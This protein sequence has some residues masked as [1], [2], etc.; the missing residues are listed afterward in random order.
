MGVKARFSSQLFSEERGTTADGRKGYSLWDAYPQADLVTY[1]SAFEGF[2]NAFVEAIYFRKPIVVNNYSIYATDIRPKGFAVIEFD[3]F[4]T[5][6]VVE[7][8]LE[9]LDS[10]TLQA[11]MAE[12]NY[13][14]ALRHF[15]YDMLRRKLRVQLANAFGV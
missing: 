3:E 9:V 8:T 11:E 13:E 15:S 1:P 7:H 12:K 6:E 14:L 2:G 5:D 4:V 10:P